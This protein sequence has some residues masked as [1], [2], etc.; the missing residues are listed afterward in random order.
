MGHRA[1]TWGD[2]NMLEPDRQQWHNVTKSHRTARSHQLMLRC[3]NSTSEKKRKMKK[4]EKE[5]NLKT[6]P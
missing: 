5:G 4:C 3:V 6:F 2:E 1:S